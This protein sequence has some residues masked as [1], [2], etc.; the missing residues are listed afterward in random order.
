MNSTLKEIQDRLFGR[1]LVKI[2]NKSM[3]KKLGD[4]EDMKRMSEGMMNEVSFRTFLVTGI[5]MMR[6][7]GIVDILNYRILRG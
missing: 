1:F 4:D 2:L 6:I 5:S 3:A 7:E